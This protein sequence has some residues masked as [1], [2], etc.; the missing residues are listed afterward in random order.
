MSA[1]E[2]PAESTD[3]AAATAASPGHYNGDRTASG[4]FP[5]HFSAR[6]LD[7]ANATASDDAAGTQIDCVTPK[8]YDQ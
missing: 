2:K 6:Y 8:S 1:I 3:H 4:W 7:A 5:N